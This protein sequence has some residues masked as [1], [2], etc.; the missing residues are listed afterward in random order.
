MKEMTL[1]EKIAFVT[2]KQN[3]HQYC[4]LKTVGEEKKGVLS[5]YLEEYRETYQLRG[6]SNLYWK[7]A[8]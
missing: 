3:K 7:T 1:E 6:C 8:N 4:D 5:I 2:G